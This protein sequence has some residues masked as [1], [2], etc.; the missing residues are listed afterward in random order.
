MNNTGIPILEVIQS[1][2]ESNDSGAGSGPDTPRV[3]GSTSVHPLSSDLVSG[4]VTTPP[5]QVAKLSDEKLLE[6]FLGV[7]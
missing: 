3:P 5:S 6:L 7:D 1:L 2:Q 4:K